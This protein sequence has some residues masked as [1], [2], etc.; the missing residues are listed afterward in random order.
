MVAFTP[1]A[2]FVGSLSPQEREALGLAEEE[3]LRVGNVSPSAVVL[4]RVPE[5]SLGAGRRDG[6]SFS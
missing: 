3:R 6:F 1:T 5:G 2:E 4:E